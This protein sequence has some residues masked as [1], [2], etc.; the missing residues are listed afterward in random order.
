MFSVLNM[1]SAVRTSLNLICCVESNER[2]IKEP[3]II[4]TL[5]LLSYFDVAER[6][7]VQRFSD[8][9]SLIDPS[10]STDTRCL[11]GFVWQLC[12]SSSFILLFP[13]ARLPKDKNQGQS[14]NTHVTLVWLKDENKSKTCLF[15]HRTF[16]DIFPPQ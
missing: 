10:P 16:L 8:M 13:C 7:S 9:V 4:E 11:G 3:L 14:E 1:Y 6:F 2:G 5:F 15:P 12:S